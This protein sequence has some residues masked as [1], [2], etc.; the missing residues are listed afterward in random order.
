MKIPDWLQDPDHERSRVW[1][2]DVRG[3]GFCPHAPMWQRRV[4]ERI[5]GILKEIPSSGWREPVLIKSHIGEARCRTRM[6]PQ[7]CIP[8]VEYL[9]SI[10]LKRI[11]TGDATVIYSGDRGFRENPPSDC[12]RYLELAKRHGW[13]EDGPLGTPYVVLDRPITSR[14]GIFEFSDEEVTLRN[15][16]GR[17]NEI[18]V[19]DG[20]M[21]AGTIINCAHLTLHDLSFVAGVVKGLAM[22]CA[23]TKGKRLLHQFC[24]PEFEK[25]RCTGCGECVK[26]CPSKALGLKGLV[27][28]LDE[29]RCTGC[30]ECIVTCESRSIRMVTKE[31]SDWM[32]AEASL[33]Y[34]LADFLVAMMDGRWE[35]LLNILH[36]YNITRMCDC[37]N[38]EQDVIIPHIG[39]LIGQN[40]F[41]IDLMARRLLCEEL[42][43]Q[44]K[45]LRSFF[46]NEDGEG[47]YEYVRRRFGIIPPNSMIRIVA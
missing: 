18:F 19:A 42:K 5:M 22:G 38:K 1:F 9:R 45:D 32:R 15:L 25:D 24:V 47:P 41:A 21:K 13:G 14:P 43:K 7:F 17:F 35:A 39:F 31:S 6:L 30:G 34:R 46:K 23:G 8:I 29:G 37:V 2:I 16:P 12:S 44:G 33:N 10:G 36:L 11:V 4:N 28:D 3:S 27:P 40:P 20:F 26:A